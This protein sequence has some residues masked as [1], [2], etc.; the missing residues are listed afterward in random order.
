MDKFSVCLVGDGPSIPWLKYTF[1][2]SCNEIMHVD[3]VQH[4]IEDAIEWK[5]NIIFVDVPVDEV[6]EDGL[7]VA[8]QLEDT[9]FRLAAKCSCAIV[10]KTP[11]SPDL[12][13]R[14]CK[15]NDKFIY[16][17]DMVFESE[18]LGERVSP[19]FMLL[20]A[21]GQASMAIQEIFY[22]FGKATPSQFI[23]VSPCEAALIHLAQRSYHAMKKVFFEQLSDVA[24][25][26]D[27]DY[28]TIQL[29]LMQDYRIGGG[30]TRVPNFDYTRGYQNTEHLK[31]LTRFNERFTLLKEVD[32]INEMYV[33][34][35]KVVH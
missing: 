20:G 9:V 19:Q 1:S 6:Q 18:H 26:F 10:I 25:E 27:T 5:P 14:L 34:R 28:H 2:K 30:M 16:S 31:M 12:V 32:K 22:R 21:G 29:Y 3:N 7:V 8:S 17:P 11:L 13:D 24:E 15:T 4:H 35:D 33:N 23:H